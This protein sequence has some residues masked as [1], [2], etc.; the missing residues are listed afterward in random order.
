MRAASVQER[1]R[2]SKFVVAHISPQLRVSLCLVIAATLLG[3][4]EGCGWR[5]GPKTC[6]SFD[7]WSRILS[8]D[9]ACAAVQQLSDSLL[10]NK[11]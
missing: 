1:G 5:K 7:R 4:N 8:K 3:Y 6:T 11:Q 9:K 10:V 2:G